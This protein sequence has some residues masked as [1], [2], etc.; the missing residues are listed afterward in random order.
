MVDYSDCFE[1]ISGG[2]IFY[3]IKN[4]E[5]NIYNKEL[6][7]IRRLLCFIFKIVLILIGLEKGV[8]NLKELVM[9]YDGIEYLN[10]NW[11]KNFSLEEV[12]KEFCVWYYK[13]LID[14]VDVKFV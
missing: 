4:K 5:Y 2:V 13:K 12:F 6:I 8:I 7:E 9:G 11:N 10:K 1:G 3:N 14:K